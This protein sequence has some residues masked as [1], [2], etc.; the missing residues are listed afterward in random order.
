MPLRRHRTVRRMV[1]KNLVLVISGCW[2]KQN[3]E[4]HEEHPKQNQQQRPPPVHPSFTLACQAHSHP[5]MNPPSDLIRGSAQRSIPSG[6]STDA[7]ESLFIVHRLQ[8]PQRA[9][10]THLRGG[11]HD[12]VEGRGH[13]RR[14]VVGMREN[15]ALFRGDGFGQVARAVDVDSVVDGHEVGEELKRDDL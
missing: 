11:Q 15:G 4:R 9:R 6:A 7:I 10:S 14:D 1:R 2:L 12:H 13:R 5:S 8:F 3:Q